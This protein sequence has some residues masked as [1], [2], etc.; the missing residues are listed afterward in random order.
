[1]GQDRIHS[2][3][4]V[5]PLIE[6]KP[7]T[8]ISRIVDWDGAAALQT[9][10]RVQLPARAKSPQGLPGGQFVVDR[11]CKAIPCVEEG[12]SALGAEVAGVLGKGRAWNEVDS[13]GGVVDRLRPHVSGK[14]RKT[15][16]ILDAADCLQGTVTG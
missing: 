7:A 12:G 6:I 4:Q 16:S 13:I 14:T 9:N 15:V 10:D 5:R 8:G 2:R 1:M 11:R 3:H